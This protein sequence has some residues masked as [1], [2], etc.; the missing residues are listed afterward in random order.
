MPLPTSLWSSLF[1]ILSI[2]L[3]NNAVFAETFFDFDGINSSKKKTMQSAAIDAYMERLYGSDVTVGSRAQVTNG[4]GNRGRAASPLSAASDS[5]L[6]NGKGKNSGVSLSFD[7]SPI[8]SFSVDSQVFRRGVGLLVKADGVIVYQH[9]LTK[10]EKRSGIMESI[11]PIFFDKPIHTLEF[12]GINKTKIAIDD[13]TVNLDLAATSPEGDLEQQLGADEAAQ[14]ASV[15]E[16][17]SFVMIGLGLLI[18]PWLSRRL[19]ARSTAKS[20]TKAAQGQGSS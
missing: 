3:F 9:L 12:V 1:L 18:A 7:A 6:K 15:S 16:P 20:L 4:L 10:A 19:R 14:L 5:Y 8:S 13:L 17:S 2:I 11:D